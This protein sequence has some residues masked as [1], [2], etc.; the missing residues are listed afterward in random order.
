VTRPFRLAQL[1]DPH[2]GA[3][4]GGGPD[5]T[6]AFTAALD[7]IAALPDRPDAIVVSGD[8]T[9][10]GTAEQ[11]GPV[12]DGLQRAGVPFVVLPGNHDDRATLRAAFGLPGEAG[13]PIRSATDLGPL[14][15]VALDT[16]IPGEGRGT[17]SGDELAWLDAA[18]THAPDR[19]TLVAMHHPPVLTGV[20]PWDDTAIG[21]AERAGLARVLERHPQVRGLAAGHL[22]RA[23]TAGFA[24]RP[25]VV[26]P[27]TYRQSLLDWSCEDFVL[28]PEPPAFAVHVLRDGELVSHLQPIA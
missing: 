16:T 18:L 9:N 12:R 28:V 20:R 21:S 22:H 26:V 1:T 17:L 15:L 23:L 24:G 19:P 3:D 10:D 25:L 8:L 5:P 11:Y 4:W 2:I 13:A 6:T 7:A 27:S 14:R